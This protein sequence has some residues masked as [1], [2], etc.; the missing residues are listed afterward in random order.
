MFPLLS[1]QFDK[2]PLIAVLPDAFASVSDMKMCDKKMRF[3]WSWIVLN[4][5][6][7]H[8]FVGH[9]FVGLRLR[10]VCIRRFELAT[11]A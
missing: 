1:M 9:L 8:L 5:F 10:H 6:V 2:L 4:V 3:W 11:D 7:A